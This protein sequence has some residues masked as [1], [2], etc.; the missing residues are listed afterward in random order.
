MITQEQIDNI[1]EKWFND[2]GFYYGPG[3][4]LHR[5]TQEVAFH[6][7]ITL[8]MPIIEKQNEALKFYENEKRYHGYYSNR[9]GENEYYH[10]EIINDGGD[11]ARSTQ[12]EVE[13]YL[14]GVLQ[15]GK[16]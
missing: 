6:A 11:T 16:I 8:V 14:K 9:S 3:F 15:E 2:S 4:E 13:E 7:A 10:G 5:N 1:F 12:K